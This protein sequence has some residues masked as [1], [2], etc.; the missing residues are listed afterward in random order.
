MGNEMKNRLDTMES[1]K[2]NLSAILILCVFIMASGIRPTT[3]T[4]VDGD[5][6]SENDVRKLFADIIAASN[7]SEPEDIQEG[8]E[9]LSAPNF[10]HEMK[11]LDGAATV[12]N[13]EQYS[14]FLRDLLTSSDPIT[15]EAHIVSISMQEDGRSA[16]VGITAVETVHAETGAKHYP[17]E[18]TL[19]VCKIDGE[20]LVTRMELKCKTR[21]N[22][23]V[24]LR[25]AG[26]KGIARETTEEGV[27]RDANDTDL[28]SSCISITT[29]VCRV[30]SPQQATSVPDR[31]HSL[32][33]KGKEIL[34]NG[35]ET[36]FDV[37][38]FRYAN[39]EG[40]APHGNVFAWDKND[41]YILNPQ[42]CGGENCGG[43]YTG[44]YWAPMGVEYPLEFRWLAGGYATDEHFIY[45]QWH[46]GKLATTKI[47]HFEVLL[48][49]E[50][51]M[52]FGH[53]GV[54]WFED[55]E[56]LGSEEARAK[57][58]KNSL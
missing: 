50:D 27:K 4:S 18:G 39:V 33:R 2:E 23:I 57:L 52:L 34:Y 37:S 38:S 17:S 41:V 44:Y 16:V 6:L 24:P 30:D 45:N 40:C 3:K 15:I 8:I 54:Y 47:S 13:R 51:E 43:N 36:D 26:E 22:T 42:S 31:L 32:R 49:G 10:V 5:K 46:H 28:R 7:R 35:Q 20:L 48:C 25:P 58:Q 56:R 29:E 53:D 1:W 14:A 55:G 12:R 11:C 21:K 19:H 9:A